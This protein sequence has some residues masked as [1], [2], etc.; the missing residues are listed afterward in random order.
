MIGGLHENANY[1]EVVY[2]VS[3]VKFVGGSGT[4]LIVIKKVNVKD[5]S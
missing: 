3:S 1:V 2:A 5:L 4:V